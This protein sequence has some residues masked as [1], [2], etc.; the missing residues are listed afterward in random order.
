MGLHQK[1]RAAEVLEE[2][3]KVQRQHAERQMDVCNSVFL[4]MRKNAS[5]SIKDVGG[6]KQL[7][8]KLKI[9]TG[10]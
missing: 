3:G 7:N 9:F 4:K 10:D 5:R 6:C 1:Q 2:R 8:P